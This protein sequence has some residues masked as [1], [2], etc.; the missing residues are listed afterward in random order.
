MT[1]VCSRIDSFLFLAMLNLYLILIYTVNLNKWISFFLER[2]KKY[3]YNW[4]FTHLNWLVYDDWFLNTILW[5]WFFFIT[6][7]FHC[8][9]FAS[10]PTNDDSINIYDVDLG[11]SMCQHLAFN[12][13]VIPHLGPWKCPSL[14]DTSLDQQ[15]LLKPPSMLVLFVKLVWNVNLVLALMMCP[16]FLPH[17]T[18]TGWSRRRGMKTKVMTLS[19]SGKRWE[20]FNLHLPLPSLKPPLS[21]NTPNKIPNFRS[22]HSKLV[23]YISFLF[24]IIN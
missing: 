17:Q 24:K 11:F 5:F 15:R 7:W 20:N 4:A 23:V 16:Y 14:S 6:A 9:H 1:W 22:R 8:M 18:L 12:F 21:I 3:S 10:N 13:W 2:K 19:S